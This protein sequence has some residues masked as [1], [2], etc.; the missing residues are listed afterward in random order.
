MKF[1]EHDRNVT[2]SKRTNQP[3]NPNLK[4]QEKGES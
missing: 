2:D 3:R 1:Y 4:G